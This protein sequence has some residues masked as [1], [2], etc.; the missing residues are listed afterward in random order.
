MEPQGA[1]PPIPG[2]GPTK[3]VLDAANKELQR[4]KKLPWIVGGVG[5]FVVLIFS[6]VA[7]QVTK[8]AAQRG[9]AGEGISQ[10]EDLLV[11]RDSV[12]GVAVEADEI[13][14][15]NGT[16]RANGPFI[17]E[18]SDTPENPA[19]GQLYF[20]TIDKQFM[21]FDGE[22]HVPI[23]GTASGTSAVASLQGQTG[24]ITLTAGDGINIVGTTIS[25][26]GV[27]SLVAGSNTSVTSLGGGAFQIATTTASNVALKNSANTFTATNV[28]QGGNVGIGDSSPAALLSVGNGDLF[29]VNASGQIEA[30][31]GI[32]S[33]G[34]IR[35]TGLD[36]SGN[37]NG[38]ALTADATGLISCSNDDGGA[39]GGAPTSSE[40]VV[41]SLDAALSGERVL[42]AG[43]NISLADGGANGNVSLSVVNSPT[44]TGTVTAGAVTVSGLITANGGLTIQPGDTLAFNG[45]LFDDLTGD[46]LQI[47]AGDL[48]VDST[49]CRT[50]GNCSGVGGNGDILNEGQAGT[51]RIG[52]NDATS[53]FFETNGL[54][55][56]TINSTGLATFS[57]SVTIQPSSIFTFNGDAFDDLTGD[58]LTIASGDLAVDSTVCRTSGNCAGIGGTGDVLQNG[59]SFGSVMT[60]GTNDTFDLN[61]ETDGTT[62]L[63]IDT[64]GNVGIGNTSPSYTLDVSGQARILNNYLTV[65]REDDTANRDIL[66]VSR[67]AGNNMKL[68]SYG[69]GAGNVTGLAITQNNTPRF[70]VSGA[71]NVA[72]GNNTAPASLFSVGATNNFQV[73]SMGAITAA[74]GVTS[75]GSVVF[76]GLTPDRLV[77]TTAGG[78]LVSSIS[79]ANLASSITDETGSGP[80]VFSASPTFTGTINAAALTASGLVTTNGGLTVQ[81]GDDVTVNGDVLRDLTGDGLT[82]NTFALSLDSTVCRTSGNCAGVGGT[83]DVLQGGNSFGATMTIGTNDTNSLAFETDGTTRWTID[84]SGDLLPGADDTYNIGS[85]TARVQDLYLGPASLHIGTDGDEGVMSYLTASNTFSFNQSGL[86]DGSLRV[87]AT[88]SGGF[89][90]SGAAYDNTSYDVSTQSGLTVA[91]EFGDSGSYL[92]VNNFSADTIYRYELSTPYDITT[93]TYSGVN[94]AYTDTNSQSYGFAFNDDGTHMYVQNETSERLYQYELSTA[95][96]ISTA[97]YTSGDS[98]TASQAANAYATEFSS[99]GTKLYILFANDTIYQ[100]SLSTPWDITPGSPSYDSISLSTSAQDSGM[101]GFEF[102]ADGTKLFLIGQTNDNV[103]EYGLVTPWNISTAT[104]SSTLLD[105]SSELTS[106][107]GIAVNSDG[108]KFYTTGHAGTNANEVSQYSFGGVTYSNGNLTVDQN[109]TFGGAVGVGTISPVE[110]LV[111]N[112]LGTENTVFLLQNADTGSTASDGFEL[113]LGS[114]ET[115]YLWNY[116]NTDLVIGTNNAEIIRVESTGEVGIGTSAPATSLHVAGI[117]TVLTLQDADTASD[118]TSYIS[119][120]DSGSSEEARL[121]LTTGTGAFEFR[122][123][124]LDEG[125]Y[126]STH[127]GDSQATRLTLDGDGFLGIGTTSP[128]SALHIANKGVNG[129]RFE[130]TSY[131]TFQF[132]Q[133]AGL[134]LTLRNITDST[135][136]IY[137]NGAGSIGVNT[138]SPAT[139]YGLTVE[140]TAASTRDGIRI[141][142]SANQSN[143]GLIIYEGADV[144]HN[145]YTSG[146]NGI[147]EI[148]DGTTANV[149]RLHSNG[150]SYLNGGDVGIGTSSPAYEFD[151]RGA[152]QSGSASIVSAVSIPNTVGN[153]G[154]FGT[155]TSSGGSIA[156]FTGHIVTAG[157]FPNSVGRFDLWAQNGSTTTTVLTG[158]ASGQVGIGTTTPVAGYELNVV[159]SGTNNGDVR[160]ASG[161]G[162]YLDLS[163]INGDDAVINAQNDLQLA[164]SGTTVLTLSGGSGVFANVFANA[165]TANT[166]YY[167]TSTG[168]LSYS[169]SSARYKKDIV[170]LEDDFTKIL[171]AR[172]VYYTDK[173]NGL[174]L[175]GFIAE[176]F[177]ALGLNSLVAYDKYG[178]PD[179]ITYE[180]IP[181]YNLGVLKEHDI[182]IEQLEQVVTG[183]QSSDYIQNG[184][185]AH[186]SEINVTGNASIEGTLSVAAIETGKLFVN[187]H[188]VS[189]SQAPEIID[190]TMLGEAAEGAVSAL[191]GT[192]TAGT[193]SLTTAARL[194]V[195]VGGDAKLVSVGFVDEYV[196]DPRIALT[197]KD[198]NA[199]G[200]PVYVRA[201]RTGFAVYT[202]AAL[203]PETTYEWDYI[204][205]GSETAVHE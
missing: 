67:G 13:L 72:V 81:T 203:E 70:F 102:S 158:T 201:T 79:S 173:A 93:A 74:T 177:H 191:E 198:A 21:Y 104:Y 135:N 155:L 65:E 99:D 37:L 56:L 148:G 54:D 3:L 123:T 195:G 86:F 196:A 69:D 58:G 101:Q 157:D 149:V 98:F 5:F 15:V 53:L 38:G 60:L 51:V 130:R 109:A 23:T 188:I 156:G 170:T 34:T 9:T 26:S 8:N 84:T 194:P 48:T 25:S 163:V 35:F 197:P 121:G 12:L 111:V 110:N 139:G 160:V 171:Q 114:N 77:A 16:L 100:Y 95:W 142:L 41:L 118:I 174:R 181:I 73:N 80:L 144:T 199:V 39:G 153:R 85:S 166:V 1:Q 132:Q 126:W 44:F 106:P 128:Q 11:P 31:S 167:N 30:A 88:P 6:F 202:S 66:F 113:S 63:T 4:S 61:L 22:Q 117:S 192:D 189:R 180:K 129:L 18:P 124:Q 90:L 107:Y 105:I 134:G 154:G 140:Q 36:C 161:G 178:R 151:V 78:Q 43:T 137:F 14:E 45:D 190:S 103:Y 112:G 145:L 47:T 82:V 64:S 76:S 91:L 108:S 7:F 200:L 183:F 122:N 75:S 97:T 162:T 59:N 28:F 143:N 147:Y 20:S 146:A 27:L 24:D 187:G 159:A 204:I 71:G 83:G 115:T 176:E 33:S 49:V 89:N 17:I 131:D 125:F 193:I 50:S 169:S 138:D 19:E 182:R 55:R 150:I 2:Q 184:D 136:P 172:P 152:A 62:R 29:R 42:T 119:F 116:E 165:S 10:S 175:T 133:S 94:K 168:Q 205:I 68:K 164:G 141:N 57:G 120:T 40:Y 92:F 32:T 179:S 46:G 186:F 127:D 185:N 96:D 87:K 52:T